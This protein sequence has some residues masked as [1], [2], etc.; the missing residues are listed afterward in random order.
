MISVGV[1]AVDHDLP[2]GCRDDISDGCDDQ[3]SDGYISDIGAVVSVIRQCDKTTSAISVGVRA[4]ARDLPEGRPAVKSVNV[5]LSV[6]AGMALSV[7]AT[8]TVS[9][10][11]VKPV[12]AGAVVA[13]SVMAVTAVSVTAPLV[14]A[15]ITK[16]AGA[17][18]TSSAIAV[19]ISALVLTTRS[20]MADMI[21]AL[22]VM[23]IL[24]IRDGC[25][26]NGCYARSVHAVECD[27][28]GGACGK[29][30]RGRIRARRA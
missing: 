6:N 11:A 30:Q 3:I 23:T 13:V 25:D 14:M 2:E 19:D 8:M 1:R 12:S 24:D 16:S 22:A 4:G 9:V 5:N 27:L 17:V 21:S 10:T 28:P 20:A 18:V 7:M 26:D 29:G 15:V